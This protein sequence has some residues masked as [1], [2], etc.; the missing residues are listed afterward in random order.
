MAKRPKAKRRSH[1]RAPADDVQPDAEL[2]QNL[3]A[4]EHPPS[5][6]TAGPLDNMPDGDEDDEDEGDVMGD[7]D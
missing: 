7:G 2:I 5:V 4:C 6:C 3:G 1:K